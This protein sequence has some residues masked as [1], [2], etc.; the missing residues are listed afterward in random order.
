IGRVFDIADLV[1]VM[2]NE[3]GF[4]GRP[5]R[6]TTLRRIASLRRSFTETHIGVDIGVDLTT[7]PL[8]RKAGATHIAAASTI[9]G[10]ADPVKAYRDLVRVF[11]NA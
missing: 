11:S 2:A 7:A 3:P 10:A 9:F 6:K 5:F 4:S 1:L 8:L